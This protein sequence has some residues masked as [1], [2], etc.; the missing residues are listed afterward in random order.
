MA[1]SEGSDSPL[2]WFAEGAGDSVDGRDNSLRGIRESRAKPDV[3]SLHGIMGNFRT[4][5]AADLAVGLSADQWRR[6]S[7]G[8][9][10][11]RRD[12]WAKPAQGSGR[13]SLLEWSAEGRL[14]RFRLPSPP[15]DHWLLIRRSI[16]DPED[17]AFEDM[18]FEDMGFEDMGFEDMGFYVTFGPPT[19]E[20]NARAAVAG[21]RGTIAACFPAA[22][23]ETG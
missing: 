16:A 9:G 20:L 17:M 6:R 22:K 13:R 5:T 18:A 1:V 15:S 7:A 19:T 4:P 23:G 8:E 12:D 21:L 11:K 14:R 2:S 10:S 3:P